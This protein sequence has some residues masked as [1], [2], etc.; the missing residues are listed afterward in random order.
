MDWIRDEFRT[1]D[2]GDARLERRA[3][4]LLGRLF[5]D[6]QAS[7]NAAC[8]GWA[9][10]QAAY[11][12]FDNPSVTPDKILAPHTDATV[13]RARL[14]HVILAVQDSTE[15][16]FS[17]HPPDG[18]GPLH[19]LAQLGF[20]DHTHLALTPEGLCLGVLG[21]DRHARSPD[22]FGQAKSRQYDPIQSKETF[23]WL[24]GYRLACRLAEQ[25]GPDTLVVSV[26]DCE[27]DLYEVFAEAD[28]L[29]R[30]APAAARA[31]YVVRMGKDRSLTEPDPASGPDA[32]RKVRQELRAAPVL[33]T[34]RLRLRRTPKRR[35]RAADL[36]VR[37]CAVELKAPYRKGVS[38]PGLRVNV[39]W[40]REVGAPAGV[41][42]VEW[43]LLTSLP[44]DTAE[45]VLLVVDYYVGRWPIEVFFRVYKSGCRV[46]EV[47]LETAARLLP[48]LMLYKV[49]AWRVM[50]L[51]ALGREVPEMPCDV[52]FCERE[53]K[54]V[55][56]VATGQAPPEA[57]PPL[58]EMVRLLGQLGGHN[59]RKGDG[60]PGAEAVWRGVRRMAD[61]A[62]AWQTFGPGAHHSQP[63]APK[64]NP[65]D[66]RTKPKTCV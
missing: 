17:A 58:G 60:P 53:W 52:A 15:L 66:K 41:E 14:H 7:V 22:G 29:A 62:L 38:L 40:V 31:E 37:A 18:A 4:L 1:L 39:V 54:P 42:A 45:R 35:P 16:D 49:V 59:G 50:Y 5:A 55:W 44:I 6:P 46:E 3:A 28:G 13:A 21:A 8:Q 57:A 9:E 43:L 47:R 63:P 32:Y 33:A 10:T 23:R 34:R 51:T 48:C 61:L 27:G 30:Q 19:S 64:G 26:A 2:L 25:V 36:E 11:R 12:F 56:Q 65:P 20:L 24:L